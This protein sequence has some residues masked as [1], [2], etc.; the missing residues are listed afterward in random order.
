MIAFLA[1]SLVGLKWK[2][3]TKNKIC[4]S[5]QKEVWRNIYTSDSY[6]DMENPKQ[7]KKSGDTL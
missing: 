4:S 2:S 1:W 3:N 6:V 7:L 5:Q